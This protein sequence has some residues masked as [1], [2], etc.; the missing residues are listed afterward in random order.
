MTMS[1]NARAASYVLMQFVLLALL[2]LAPRDP[3][4]YGGFRAALSVV[5]LVLIA[6]GM[7]VILYSFFA[8]GKSLT[9]SPV[10]KQDGTLVTSGLYARVRHPIYFGLLLASIGVVLDA[11]PW[12]Q[13]AIVLL[14]YV[15]LNIKASYEEELLAKRYPEYKAY[16]QKTPRFFPRIGS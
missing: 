9:A 2:I 15:L 6:A 5:G 4:V 13:F 11:G 10:P 14:L 7:A 12:P 1:T 8:L 16:A 3:S